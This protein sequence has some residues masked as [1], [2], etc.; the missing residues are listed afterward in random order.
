MGHSDKVIQTGS[1]NRV[2]IIELSRPEKFN[3]LSG[4]VARAI[5][6]APTGHL[7][8]DGVRVILIRAQGR[9]F[10]TGADL[11]EVL[12]LRQDEAKLRAFIAYDQSVF[13]RLEPAPSPVVVAVRGLCL[14]GGIELMMSCDVA[15]AGEGARL[16][17][18]RAQ[19]GLVPG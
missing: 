4:K 12:A 7:A 10:C 16:G 11:D 19:Y 2:G 1:A 9:H 5:D 14:A 6:E 13:S 3:C 8:D 18:Q 17:D 15:F